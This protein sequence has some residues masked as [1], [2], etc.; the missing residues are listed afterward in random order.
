[1]FRTVV[2]PGFGSFGS[3]IPTKECGWRRPEIRGIRSRISSIF[4]PKRREFTPSSCSISQFFPM[5]LQNIRA[6]MFFPDRTQQDEPRF[7]KLT[8]RQCGGQEREWTRMRQIKRTSRTQARKETTRHQSENHKTA[9]SHPSCPPLLGAI[10]KIISFDFHLPPL[11][12][13]VQIAGNLRGRNT[14][15]GGVSLFTYPCTDQSFTPFF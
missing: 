4:G 7:R 8:T 2:F 3:K 11:S 1:M 10:S 14:P 13:S 15:G 5:E 9:A 6:P 12:P